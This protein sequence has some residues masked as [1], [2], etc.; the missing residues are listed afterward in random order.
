MKPEGP[1]MIKEGV[2]IQIPLEGK[3][4]IDQ[5]GGG[6]RIKGMD[7]IP[8]NHLAKKSKLDGVS[9]LRSPGST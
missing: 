6:A 7:Q 3:L 2:I 1:E 8:N 5:V 9:I 4:Q